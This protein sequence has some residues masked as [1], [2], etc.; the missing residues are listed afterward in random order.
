MTEDC[1]IIPKIDHWICVC[2]DESGKYREVI[3]QEYEF[4]ILSPEQSIRVIGCPDKFALVDE[5]DVG[6]MRFRRVVSE[7][8]LLEDAITAFNTMK[9]VSEH[10]RSM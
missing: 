6:I 5:I 7:T 2:Q 3:P 10:N 1:G 8:K 9:L 4:A